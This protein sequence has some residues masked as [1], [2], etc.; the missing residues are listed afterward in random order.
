MPCS[1]ITLSVLKQLPVSVPSGTKTIIWDLEMPGFG[2][3][4]TSKG[5]ISFLYQYR[6]PGG[7]TKSTRIGTLGELT[8]EQARG[9]AADH[10]HQR[11]R[12]IDPIAEIKRVIEEQQAATSLVLSTYAIE[13]IQRRKDNAR[14]LNQAQERIVTRDVVGLLGEKRIDKLTIEDVEGFANT[15]AERGPSARRMGLVYLKMILNEAKARG[16]ITFSAADSVETNKS[17]ERSRRLNRFELLRYL[18]ASREVGDVRS[19]ILEVLVR[20]AKRKLE[21]SEM[22]WGE[23]D[24]DKREW[25]LGSVRTKNSEPVRIA[26]PR[27]VVE[28]IARQQP[29]PRLR[30]GPVFTLDG[31]TSPEMGGQVKELIDSYM[32]R[33]VLLANERD[34][35]AFTVEHFTIHDLRTTVASMLEEIPFL[36][37]ASVIN[38]ILLHK[39]EG[40]VTRTYQRATF[41]IEA[42]EA[43]QRW[44]DYI[45]E[46]MAGP[47]AWPGGRDLPP[48][49]GAE[50]NE[51]W[52]A[53][54][55]GWP[56]RSDQR[57]ARERREAGLDKKRRRGKAK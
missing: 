23:I 31:R 56:E 25:F 40:K 38:A 27:Q 10:A 53:F 15:L 19:D 3:Y 32:H 21:V 51:M 16:K 11:R 52:K 54:R 57:R 8:I 41:S 35:T 39:K 12:G 50:R 5:R 28:I 4:R 22:Q 18:E 29:D 36:V 7:V 24:L 49:R 26:L 43:L 47:D 9:I 44:N 1:R 46:L 48:L 17:G 30:V 6:M 14:P 55:K 20:M 34:A 33:R 13:F 2:A 42:G 45:D 37:P